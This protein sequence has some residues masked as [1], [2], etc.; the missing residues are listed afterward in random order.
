MRGMADEVTPRA[1]SARFIYLESL[2]QCVWVS[3]WIHWFCRRR[4]PGRN[5]PRFTQMCEDLIYGMLHREGLFQ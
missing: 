5:E 1:A 4:L 2:C 3:A